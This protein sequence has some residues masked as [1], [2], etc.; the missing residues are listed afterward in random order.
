MSTLL[1]TYLHTVLLRTGPWQVLDSLA[2]C[3]L[4]YVVLLLVTCTLRTL[5]RLLWLS[6]VVTALLGLGLHA[7]VTT[8]QVEPLQAWLL[9]LTLPSFPRPT[10]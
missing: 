7:L 1:S 9:N 6:A 3:S 5:H 2:L 4:C 10:L 8:Q